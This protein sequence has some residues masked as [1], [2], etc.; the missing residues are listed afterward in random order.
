LA[1]L[2]ATGFVGLTLFVFVVLGALRKVWRARKALTL[3]DQRF[4]MAGASLAS[5]ILGTLFLWALG[6]PD[7]SV[8]WALLALAVAYSHVRLSE[9]A[10]DSVPSSP[11]WTL[12]P[13]RY[14]GE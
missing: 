2:L 11:A 1:E 4:G 10:A 14:S 13:P 5:C 6:G 12:L 3:I 9:H 7:P 8:L